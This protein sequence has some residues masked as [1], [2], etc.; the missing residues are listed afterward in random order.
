MWPPPRN[1]LLWLKTSLLI[2][3]SDKEVKTSDCKIKQIDEKYSLGNIVN[4]TVVVLYG[5]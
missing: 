4:N 1:G 5:D 2:G 3:R